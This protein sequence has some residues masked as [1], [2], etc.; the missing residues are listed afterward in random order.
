MKKYL[1]FLLIFI[2]A[3]NSQNINTTTTLQ[4][5][6]TTTINDITSTTVQDTT[7]TTLQATTSTTIQT[8]TTLQ[9]ITKVGGTLDEWKD[10][11]NQN[12]GTDSEASKGLTECDSLMAQQVTTCSQSTNWMVDN[13]MEIVDLSTDKHYE[14]QDL[15]QGGCPQ[16]TSERTTVDTKSVDSTTNNYQVLC[17]INCY[18]WDCESE[19]LTGSYSGP[20]TLSTDISFFCPSM[21]TLVHANQLTADLEDNDGTITGTATIHDLSSIELDGYGGCDIVDGPSYD[22]TVTGTKTG[23]DV[24]LTINFGDPDLFMNELT[25]D[26]KF[27]NNKISGDWSGIDGSGSVD[28]DKS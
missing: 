8:T 11:I 25:I 26:A 24:T 16:G 3:C 5:T 10:I 23:E 7:T 6:T 15:Q 2:I 4:D 18:S 13:A 12:T 20:Y 1:L 21:P 28:I 27:N 17:S 19:S 14:Y 9:E 22:G